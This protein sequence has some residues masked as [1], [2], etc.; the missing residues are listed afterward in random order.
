MINNSLRSNIIFRITLQGKLLFLSSCSQSNI[1]CYFIKASYDSERSIPF[2]II[3]DRDSEIGVLPLLC[4]YILVECAPYIL[5]R[6]GVSAINPLS[7]LILL[8]DSL[9]WMEFWNSCHFSFYL[10]LG[11]CSESEQLEGMGLFS[12]DMKYF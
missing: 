11:F 7:G 8:L 2:S 6:K 9:W 5:H 3:L 12:S 10:R 1:K 4:K